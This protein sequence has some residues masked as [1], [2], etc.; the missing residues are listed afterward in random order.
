[1]VF[2]F[3]VAA[4]NVYDLWGSWI[5]IV[6]LHAVAC[7]SAVGRVLDSQ[8]ILESKAGTIS[9]IRSR[10]AMYVFQGAA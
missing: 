1:V 2:P 3:V 4:D 6:G 10:S 8:L 7:G 9:S 5:R